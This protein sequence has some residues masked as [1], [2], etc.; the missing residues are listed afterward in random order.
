M[1]PTDLT[2]EWP[3]DATLRAWLPT[4]AVSALTD[5]TI[6]GEVV[7]DATADV[8][9]ELDPDRLPDDG[10]CPRPVARAIVLEAARLL[11]RRQSSHGVAAFSELAIRLRDDPDSHRLLSRW[12]RGYAP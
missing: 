9:D 6:L 4:D 3:T 11:Y 5:A 2:T 7:A 1:A 8:F 12:V 10:S